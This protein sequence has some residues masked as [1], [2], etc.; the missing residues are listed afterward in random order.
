MRSELDS[1]EAQLLGELRLEVENR[2][3]HRTTRSWRYWPQTI[4]A[5]FVAMLCGTVA[6]MTV[7]S[8]P[9]FAV[10][11]RAGG[12]VEVKVNRLEDAAGLER[13]LEDEGVNADISYLGEGKKCAPGR[14]KESADESYRSRSEYS[15]GGNGIDVKLDLRDVEDGK[16]LV[17]AVSSITNGSAG[18]IGIADGAVGPC[19]L[20][21]DPD[22]I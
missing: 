15:V 14:Y 1:F 16:T 8:A 17:I 13:A 7:G 4:A 22:G 19:R 6:V 3:T 20:I 5:T 12:I 9:A 18:S 11:A 21:D 2:S 10:D